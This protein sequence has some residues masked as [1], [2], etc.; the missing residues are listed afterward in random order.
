MQVDI[1]LA[2]SL[3]GLAYSTA[4]GIILERTSGTIL[5][6]IIIPVIDPMKL[7]KGQSSDK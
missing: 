4:R 6:G 5:N 2:A 3:V 1:G 7:L